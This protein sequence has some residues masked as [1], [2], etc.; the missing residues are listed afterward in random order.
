MAKLPK[1]L[2][3]KKE[4]LDFQL[5]EHQGDNAELSAEKL[6]MNIGALKHFTYM[7]TLEFGT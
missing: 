1:L 4:E 7:G 5:S 6:S 3:V 2:S